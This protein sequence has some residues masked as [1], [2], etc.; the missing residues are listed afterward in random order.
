MAEKP[1]KPSKHYSPI[2]VGLLT[3]MAYG[4]WFMG[5]LVWERTFLDYG[6]YLLIAAVL[7][8][9]LDFA[10][11][12]FFEAIVAGLEGIFAFVDTMADWIKRL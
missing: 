8:R 3:F 5:L 2:I 11:E 7:I 1:K 4:I 9:F 6:A 10:F 12:P